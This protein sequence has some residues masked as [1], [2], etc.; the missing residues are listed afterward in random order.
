MTFTQAFYVLE[1]DPNK[2]FERLSSISLLE[3]KQ[4]ALKMLEECRKRQKRLLGSSHPDKGGDPNRFLE[5]HNAFQLIETE[6]ESFI[7]KIDDKIDESSKSETP[8][9]IFN[10]I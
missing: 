2:Y 7:R 3:K 5:I 4:L 9:L 10:K 8:I 1:I 6:T